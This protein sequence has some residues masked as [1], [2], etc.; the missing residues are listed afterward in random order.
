MSPW[1]DFTCPDCPAAFAVDDR[2]REELL[3]IGCIRCGATV[4]AAAFGQRETA[5]PSAT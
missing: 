1:Y 3:D 2:A 5:P 4:T